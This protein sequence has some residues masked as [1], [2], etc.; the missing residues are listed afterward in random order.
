VIELLGLTIKPSSSIYAAPEE[1]TFN[2]VVPLEEITF[3]SLKLVKIDLLTP[4]ISDSFNLKS[5]NLASNRFNKDALDPI[6]AAIMMSPSL[7]YLDLS[8][9]FMSL[10]AIKILSETF[11]STMSLIDVK[12]NHIKVV[13]DNAE[14]T[15]LIFE[16]MS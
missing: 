6:C 2:T 16:G 9:N 3:E 10:F 8:F 5:L 4:I 12:L 14:A 13:G 7:K 11:K 15:K 1:P